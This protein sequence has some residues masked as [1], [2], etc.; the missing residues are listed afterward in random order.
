MKKTKKY[1]I[2]MINKAK[3]WVLVKT[4]KIDK[5]LVWYQGGKNPEGMHI[6]I[7]LKRKR[8]L[9]MLHVINN[10]IFNNFSPIHLETCEK[11]KHLEKYSCNLPNMT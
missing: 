10:D 2:E 6:I 4:K 1:V 3:Y 5:L 9:S 11:D 8:E 7:G